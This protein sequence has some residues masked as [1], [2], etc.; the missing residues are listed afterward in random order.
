MSYARESGT[1]T[2]NKVERTSAVFILPGVD[3]NLRLWEPLQ[4]AFGS[5]II[6][7]L[8]WTELL[9]AS[10]ADLAAH[11][12]TQ[13]ESLSPAGEIRLIGYSLGGSLGYAVA[14]ALQTAGRPVSCLVLLDA[15]AEVDPAPKSLGRRLRERF[16]KF[17]PSL[18]ATGIAS[19]RC[20]NR[21]FNRLM[22]S[23]PYRSPAR[24]QAA[25]QLRTPIHRKIAIQSC[26]RCIGPGG[27]Q[28]L[29]PDSR[30][31]SDLPIQI[32]KTMNPLNPRGTSDG[33]ASAKI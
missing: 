25:F 11:V 4:E 13:I 31:D 20:Q 32:L 16:N 21:R 30:R 27:A 26:G 6:D 17:S 29:N 8:D 9:T 24:Y 2:E 12:L 1:S 14:K 7:Y 19:S 5:R 22:P 10:L 33:N 18:R 23:T 3:D 15:S 28:S